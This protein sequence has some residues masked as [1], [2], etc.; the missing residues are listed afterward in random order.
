MS[1]WNVCGLPVQTNSAAKIRQISETSK[2]ISG[3]FARQC[4]FPAYYYNI[5]R[6]AALISYKLYGERPLNGFRP[7]LKK[8]NYPLIRKLH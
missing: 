3:K 5:I 4:I 7:R 6:C 2:K 1:L 8:R